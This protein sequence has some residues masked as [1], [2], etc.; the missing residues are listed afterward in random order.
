MTPLPIPD[1]ICG[2]GRQHLSR[3]GVA[4]PTGKLHPRQMSPHNSKSG[5]TSPEMNLLIDSCFPS[6]VPLLSR[7]WIVPV[8]GATPDRLKWTG[9]RS[10]RTSGEWKPEGGNCVTDA[11]LLAPIGKCRSFLCRSMPVGGCTP[12]RKAP[13]PPN[14]PHN[15]KSEKTSPEMNLLIDSCFPSAVPLLSRGWIVPVGGSTPD[16]LRPAQDGLAQGL[17]A[18]AGNGNRRA[19]I[20]LLTRSC[21]R[22]LGNAG[23]SCA[24][25]GLH[26]RPES[27]TPAKYPPAIPNPERHPPELNLLIDSCFPSAVSL[28]SRGWIVPVG[29]ATPDRR[30]V[31]PRKRGME[32][33]GRTLCY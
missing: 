18:Q 16:R 11:F 1:S 9:S 23:R 30:K 5:K 29:G 33:G 31:W 24:G 7:G 15:S 21:L 32:T 22:R 26:P 20:V 3:S 28:L 2:I 12:D 14:A 17:T 27:P 10:D 4:P 19:D 6:A 25:R 8:G 13:P